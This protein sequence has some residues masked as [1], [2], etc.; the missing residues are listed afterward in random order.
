MTSVTK[1]TPREHIQRA[2]NLLTRTTGEAIGVTLTWKG[3][4]YLF[5][6]QGFRI[7]QRKSSRNLQSLLSSVHKLGVP[8]QLKPED[9]SEMLDIPT[10]RNL[11]KLN[12]ITLRRLVG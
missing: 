10:K 2:I 1:D 9:D 12:V 8:S 11:A 6:P 5:W 3:E 7:L 4:S